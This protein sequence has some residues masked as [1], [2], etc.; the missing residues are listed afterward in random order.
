[1]YDI[2]D[3]IARINEPYMPLLVFTLICGRP[4]SRKS[5]RPSGSGGATEFRLPQSV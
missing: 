2:D 3:V 4:A 5:C 1:M